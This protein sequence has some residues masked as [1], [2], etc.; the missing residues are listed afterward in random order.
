MEQEK[1][2]ISMMTA[3]MMEKSEEADYKAEL[4]MREHWDEVK[5]MSSKEFRDL[6]QKVM[7][8]DKK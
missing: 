8:D 2:S 3:E 4:Y 1:V 5:D 7:Y 6:M